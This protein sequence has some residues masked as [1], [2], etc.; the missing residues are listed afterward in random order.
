MRIRKSSMKILGTSITCSG[1]V[2]SVPKKSKMS[3]NWSSICDTGASK[4]CTTGVTG[5][6]STMCSIVC[7]WT[8]SCGRG[9][10]KASGRTPP[11]KS[12]GPRAAALCVC[13][14]VALFAASPALS[15]LYARWPSYFSPAATLS[16]LCWTAAERAMRT[17]C[18]SPWASRQ[19]PHRHRPPWRSTARLYKQRANLVEPGGVVGVISVIGVIDVGVIGVVGV[20]L[21][22]CWCGVGVGVWL[23]CCCVVVWLCGCVVVVVL[24]LLWCCGVVVL[25]CGCGW[26]WSFRTTGMSPP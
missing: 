9:S 18:C 12:S 4:V 6:K 5:T 15:V 11:W 1:S 13:L 22:W 14:R 16:K 23:L 25:W 3:G 26:W 21:V 7:R 2:V 24:W 19:R 20:L 10:V 8:R 17:V